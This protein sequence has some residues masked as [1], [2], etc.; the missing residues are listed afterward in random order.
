MNPEPGQTWLLVT[1]AAHMPRSMGI[2]RKIGWGVLPF[3]V[4]YWTTGGSEWPGRIEVGQRLVELDYATREWLGLLAYY[5]M[6]RT[7]ALLPGP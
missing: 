4:D 1:S 7:T 3:P 2:F 5:L 6:G